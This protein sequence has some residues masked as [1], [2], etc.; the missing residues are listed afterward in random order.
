MPSL[1][2]SILTVQ[3]VCRH[4]DSVLRTAQQAG[5]S[6]LRQRRVGRPW[7][8]QRFAADFSW[9]RVLNRIV[10]ARF[11]KAFQAQL[12]GVALAAGA[13]VRCRIVA[14]VREGKIEI[15]FDRFMDD[16]RF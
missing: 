14:T 7:L 16:L 9:R 6:S 5:Q 4:G 11:P 12:A 8:A 3:F 2:I 15:E 10:Y 1:P 13:A